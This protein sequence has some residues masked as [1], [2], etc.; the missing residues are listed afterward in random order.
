MRVHYGVQEMCRDYRFMQNE[1]IIY[2][3]AKNL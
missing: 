3:A 2:E 1:E